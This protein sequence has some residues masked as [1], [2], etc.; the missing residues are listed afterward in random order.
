M[1]FGF[2]ENHDSRIVLIKDENLMATY[3]PISKEKKKPIQQIIHSLIHY[4][5]H[6]RE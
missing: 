6:K 3:M 5:E 2:Q 1:Y 4:K